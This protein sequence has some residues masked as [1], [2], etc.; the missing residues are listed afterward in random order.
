MKYFHNQGNIGLGEVTRSVCRGV[1]GNLASMM[2][3]AMLRERGVTRIV[4]S[5]A[6]LIRNMVL[7]REIQAMI[8]YRMQH[9]NP[10]SHPNATLAPQARQARTRRY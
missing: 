10:L 5:G 3:P 2:T 4:G 6:C 1:I 8:I 9:L 7:Q